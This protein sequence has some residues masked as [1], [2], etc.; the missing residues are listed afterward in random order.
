MIDTRPELAARAAAVLAEA[1]SSQ[2]ASSNPAED[3][4]WDPVLDAFGVVS[5][6]VSAR[7]VRT[8]LTDQVLPRSAKIFEAAELHVG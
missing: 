6:G 3:G 8:A 7:Q 1:A 4:E 2:L 5:P